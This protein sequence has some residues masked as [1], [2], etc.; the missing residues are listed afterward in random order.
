VKTRVEPSLVALDKRKP[1]IVSNLFIDAVSN[2]VSMV[3]NGV[4]LMNK[5]S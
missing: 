5:K 2:T 3:E 1:I 4:L